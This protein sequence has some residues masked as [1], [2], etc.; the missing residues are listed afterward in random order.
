M[1]LLQITSLWLKVVLSEQRK[2]IN[3]G[4]DFSLET[5]MIVLKSIFNSS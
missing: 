2:K 3:V 5:F 1:V 4:K